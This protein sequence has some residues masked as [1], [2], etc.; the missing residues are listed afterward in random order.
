MENPS[1]VSQELRKVTVS[2]PKPYA[3]TWARL[4]PHKSSQM[5]QLRLFDRLKVS[6]LANFQHPFQIRKLVEFVGDH[7][8]REFVRTAAFTHWGRARSGDHPRVNRVYCFDPVAY[9]KT[10]AFLASW[11]CSW[12]EATAECLEDKYLSDTALRNKQRYWEEALERASVAMA[13]VGQCIGSFTN[14]NFPPILLARELPYSLEEARAVINYP[15]WRKTS[16]NGI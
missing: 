12:S 3:E 7:L 5:M 14:Q 16:S 6:N 8:H 9:D 13:K 11:G 2:V 4:Y 10:K 15:Q 1:L